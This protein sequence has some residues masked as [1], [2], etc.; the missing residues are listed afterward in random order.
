MRKVLFLLITL[1]IISCKEKVKAPVAEVVTPQMQVLTVNYELSEMSLEAHAQL[2]SDVVGN[3]APGKIS[4]LIGKTFIGNLEKGVFGGVYYFTDKASV[5]AYLASDLWK[6][7]VSHPNLVNF[8]NDIYSIAPISEV[9]NGFADKRKTA[10]EEDANTAKQLLIVKYELSE[11]SLEAHNQLGSDVVGN[12]APGKIPGL[13]GKTF[14]GN[15]EKGVFGG[16]YYFTDQ[17]SLDTYLASDLWNGI[18]SHPNLVNFKKEI[19]MIAPIS[20]VSNGLPSL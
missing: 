8:K 12:F 9:S 16:V 4:G 6:G 2:G 20:T 13:I 19:Y 17:V 14:I 11:M 18:V 7:I 1:L 3:F 15:L 5:D 10:N